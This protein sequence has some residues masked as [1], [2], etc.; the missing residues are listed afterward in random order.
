MT[1]LARIG[2]LLVTVALT[3]CG[4]DD[5]TDAGAE[6]CRTTDR[7]VVLDEQLSPGRPSSAFVVDAD[8]DVW[9]SVVADRDVSDSALLS[10]V[11]GLY[12]V[13]EGAPVEFSRDDTGAVITDAPYFGFDE[14]GQFVPF[15]SEPG[16]FQLWSI[17]SPQVHVVRCPPVD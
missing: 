16:A 14:Q 17:N 10:R 4:S 15:G 3:A 5:D 2:L 9:V 1:S 7:E 6:V 12:V 11:S 8:A 13:D